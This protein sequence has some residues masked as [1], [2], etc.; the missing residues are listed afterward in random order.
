MKAL[1]DLLFMGA[2]YLLPHHLLSRLAG[3]VA[4]CRWPWFKNRLI[5]WFV[6]AYQ[7]NMQEAQVTDPTSFKHFNDFFTRALKPG[8]REFVNAAGSI[9]SPVD[10]TI[11]QIGNI[12]AGRIFQAK[13]HEFSTYDLLGGSKALAKQFEGGKFT[14]I[15][16]SPKDYHRVHM[17]VSGTLKEMIYIPGRLFSVSPLTTSR[18]PSLFSRN[19]RMIAVFDTAL[20]TMA[21]V[22]VGAMIVASIETVWAGL[23]T[24]PKRQLQRTH[25]GEPVTLAKGDELGRFKLG[26]TAII[27]FSEDVMD[28]EQ[29]LA[30]DQSVR[31]GQLLGKTLS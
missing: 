27:L 17:P 26:S 9:A 31:L 19:E 8:A 30:A 18:I 11:S 12:E 29:S 23:V 2:Q 5:Q 15:Y 25:Y 6:K 10:G 21:V 3:C 13:G 28:W 22:M 16:L 7:V 20:G 4:E 24:P 1:K 14:T